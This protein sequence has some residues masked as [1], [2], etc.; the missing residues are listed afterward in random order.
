M[1]DEEMFVGFDLSKQAEYEEYWLNQGEAARAVAEESR[2]RTSAWKEEDFERVKREG[3]EVHKDLV[4]ALKKKCRVTDEEVQALIRRH[5]ATIENFYTPTKEI[6]LGLGALYLENPDFKKM[7]DAYH[8]DLAEF[9]VG[10]MKIFAEREL[11]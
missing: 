1:K 5:Y 6:Y 9:L 7:L 8:L 4:N 3:H 11:K 2:A 10:A